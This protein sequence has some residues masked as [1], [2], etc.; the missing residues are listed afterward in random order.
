V[1]GRDDPRATEAANFTPS[2]VTTTAFTP[3]TGLPTTSIPTGTP[4]T[5]VPSTATPPGVPAV[6]G[7]PNS[8]GEQAGGH[9]SGRSGGAGTTGMY[10]FMPM[11][12]TAGA[13]SDDSTE[14]GTNL[15]EDRDVWAVHSAVTEPRIG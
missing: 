14:V 9:G 5:L 8:W 7:G 11:G 1:I 12:G 15:S 2:S 10:P 13:G 4:T 3:T 6:L